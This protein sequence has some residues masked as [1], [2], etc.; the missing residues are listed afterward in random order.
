MN[1]ASEYKEIWY[2]IDGVAGVDNWTKTINISNNVDAIAASFCSFYLQTQVQTPS[3][4][5]L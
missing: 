1:L 3:E 4:F 5:N 2:I